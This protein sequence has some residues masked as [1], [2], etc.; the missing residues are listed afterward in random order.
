MNAPPQN[1]TG[2]SDLGAQSSD[3]PRLATVP[4]I[5]KFY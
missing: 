3:E 2:I 1:W 4:K 5:K